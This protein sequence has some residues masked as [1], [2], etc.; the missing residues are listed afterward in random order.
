[1]PTPTGPRFILS[2]PKDW[3][4]RPTLKFKPGTKESLDPCAS[5]ITTRKTYPPLTLNI[6]KSEVNIV[7]N[8]I[9]IQRANTKSSAGTSY[10]WESR[11]RCHG[12]MSIPCRLATCAIS[13]KSKLGTRDHSSPKPEQKQVLQNSRKKNHS[14][15]GPVKICN[16]KQGHYSNHRLAKDTKIRFD[17]IL[18]K[19][20][21]LNDY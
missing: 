3:H 18:W 9:T 21:W 5:A 8:V 13:P 14:A 17:M 2:R 6:Q 4:P 10:K 1:M 11:I 12:G 16:R 7:W 19:S 15:Y 20:D